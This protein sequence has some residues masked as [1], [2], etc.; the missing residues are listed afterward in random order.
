MNRRRFLATSA[1]VGTSALAGCSGDSPVAPPRESEVFEQVTPQDGTLVVRLDDDPAVESRV[2]VGG[3]LEAPAIGGPIG[4]ARAGGRGGRSG[5]SGSGSGATGRGSGSGTSY[6]GRH[7]RN[8]YYGGTYSS[9]HDDH[10]DDVEEYGAV[11]A[12]VGIAYLGSNAMSDDDLP[13]PG[14]ADEW[15]KKVEDPSQQVSYDLSQAGWYRVGGKLVAQ[16][17]SHDFGWEAVDIAIDESGSG[18]DVDEEWKVSP[19]L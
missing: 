14:P 19:R 3:D 15:D 13:G 5:R 7:G 12:A 8:K 6:K 1:L 2:D 9:W 10:D 11:V 18:Y 16:N 17:G 4:V